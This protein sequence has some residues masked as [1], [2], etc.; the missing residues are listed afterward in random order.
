MSETFRARLDAL[1]ER[2]GIAEVASFYDVQ[3]RTVRAWTEGRTPQREKNIRSVIRRA[4][5]LTGN[6]VQTR[7]DR[8]RFVTAFAERNFV[9]AFEVSRERRRRAAEAIESQ[10]RTPAQRAFAEEQRRRAEDVQGLIGE[11][12]DW[13]TWREELVE[14]LRDDWDDWRGTYEQIAG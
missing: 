6:A 11:I 3:P 13:R 8:G 7:D 1:I 12:V 5:P 9:R 10:A 4:R 14:G 2:D